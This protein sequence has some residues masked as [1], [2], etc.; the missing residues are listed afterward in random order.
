MQATECINVRT[1]AHA[2]AMIERA[3]QRL[4]VSVSS[5]MAQS[6]YE[7]ALQL[8][9]S[10]IIYLNQSEWEQAVAMLDGEPSDKMNALLARGYRAI[11][12]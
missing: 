4:G 2:K 6:A 5:F 8:E 3:S 7:K 12:R 1:N 10:E 11:G 9:Q